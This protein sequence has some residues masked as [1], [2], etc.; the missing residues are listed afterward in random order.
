MTGL[1]GGGLDLREGEVL[2]GVRDGEVARGGDSEPEMCCSNARFISR[3][4]TSSRSSAC[5]CFSAAPRST[6]DT[7]TGFRDISGG[8][9]AP[10]MRVVNRI[11]VWRTVLRER[12]A[13]ERARGD[14]STGHG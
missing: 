13:R 4:R 6:G 7:L 2:M 1:T 11:K 12:H 3:T 9:G 8:R 5:R 14:C 10:A